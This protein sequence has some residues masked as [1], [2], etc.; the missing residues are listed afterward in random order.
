MHH[1]SVYCY[2]LGLFLAVYCYFVAGVL[3]SGRNFVIGVGG[4]SC[5]WIW[6][7]GGIIGVTFGLV[8]SSNVGGVFFGIMVAVVVCYLDAATVV[9]LIFV[10]CCW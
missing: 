9:I 4:L 5:F 8:F 3:V 1:S 2:V 10:A 6:G 7:C